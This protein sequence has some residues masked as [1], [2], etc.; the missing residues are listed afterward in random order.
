[1]SCSDCTPTTSR[2]STRRTCGAEIY[3][4]RACRSDACVRPF[5][6]PGSRTSTVVA[7]GMTRSRQWLQL[8]QSSLN[9]ARSS[10]VIDIGAAGRLAPFVVPQQQ[11]RSTDHDDQRDRNDERFL[12]HACLI[13]R[14]PDARLVRPF[15]RVGKCAV[16]KSVEV[17]AALEELTEVLN[18]VACGRDLGSRFESMRSGHPPRDADHPHDP[19]REN[20]RETPRRE[21]P[22]RRARWIQ[23]RWQRHHQQ[24]RETNRRDVGRVQHPPS[25]TAE[26]RHLRNILTMTHRARLAQRQI[27]RDDLITE[28]AARPAAT[29]APIEGPPHAD[30]F[31]RT[32]TAVCADV[33]P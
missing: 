31:R 5:R 7:P 21:Q 14:G 15:E 23:L 27:R 19:E 6:K 2:W 25:I 11:T 20:A 8:Q 30:A 3:R 28:K 17:P 24:H 13:A 10:K 16:A 32:A 29:R 33:W 26:P 22:C 4:A 18:D 1:M 12:P 9:L